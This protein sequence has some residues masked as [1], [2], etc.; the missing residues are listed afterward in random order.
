VR[1]AVLFYVRRRFGL[2][3]GHEQR[4]AQEQHIVLLR[5]V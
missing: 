3:E 1:E 2:V 5:I 4:P